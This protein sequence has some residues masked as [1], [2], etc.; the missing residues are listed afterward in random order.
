LHERV[1]SAYPVLEFDL[2]RI[3]F[4]ILFIPHELHVADGTGVIKEQKKVLEE[5]QILLEFPLQGSAKHGMMLFHA[6]PPPR[7][8]I[9]AQ[10]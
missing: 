9:C 1:L 5:F 8:K 10:E 3:K 7:N 2:L 4:L 6:R